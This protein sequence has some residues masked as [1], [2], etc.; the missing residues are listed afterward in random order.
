MDNKYKCQMILETFVGENLIDYN[1]QFEMNRQHRCER[2]MAKHSI[3]LIGARSPTVKV[4]FN[5]KKVLFLYTNTVANVC[6]Y[7]TNVNGIC[8]AARS[9]TKFHCSIITI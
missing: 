9:A 6:V 7:M 5:R 1:N 2:R 8:Y 3:I 4:C